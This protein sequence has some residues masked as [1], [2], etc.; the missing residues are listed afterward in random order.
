MAGV[1]LTEQLKQE[2]FQKFSSIQTV[3]EFAKV[4]NWIEKNDGKL[5]QKIKKG[6]IFNNPIDSQHLHYLSKT[7]DTRY[8]HFTIEKKSG[9]LR[10]I[11]DP[12]IPLK[13]VQTL[14]N[15]LLQVVFSPKAHYCTNGF[16][17][18]RDIVRNAKPH[19]N[20]KYVLNC[21]IKDFF[22]SINFGRVRAVLRLSPFN[23]N[24]EKE[25]IANLI[26]SIS[27]YEN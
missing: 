6:E 24:G 14:V 25:I 5:T 26:A 8:D 18:G 2:L 23:F 17:Y 27:T 19:L 4:L 21:D 15:C 3:T 16:T 11:R 20:K 22:S 7:K 10:E 13:R 12:D 1:F 9:S